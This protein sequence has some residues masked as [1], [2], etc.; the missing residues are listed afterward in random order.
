MLDRLL[1]RNF[2]SHGIENEIMQNKKDQESV[3]RKGL[4]TGEFVCLENAN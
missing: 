3:E 1:C 4:N 2:C